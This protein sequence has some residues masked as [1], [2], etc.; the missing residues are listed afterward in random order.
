MY[1]NYDLDTLYLDTLYLDIPPE[2]YFDAASFLLLQQA[3]PADGLAM[4]Q[5]FAFNFYS[6]YSVV[7]A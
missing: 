4:I 5:N 3:I 7:A 6:E 2:G 1:F